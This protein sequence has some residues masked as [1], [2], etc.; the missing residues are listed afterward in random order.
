MVG[1]TPQAQVS[2]APA[3]SVATLREILAELKAEQPPRRW[4]K[5]ALV[6]VE[7]PITPAL[8][9]ARAWWVGSQSGHGEYWVCHLPCGVWTCTCK[10]HEQ[11][12]E[13][14]KHVLACRILERC[15][16]REGDSPSGVG[17][18]G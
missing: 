14:C 13:G 18:S 17:R 5:G 2:T 6:L 4:D 12:G 1:I 16:D 10:D 15:Q 7:C 11:R 3:I 8:S 9:G